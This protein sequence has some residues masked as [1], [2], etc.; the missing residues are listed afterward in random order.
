[1]TAIMQYPFAVG[2]RGTHSVSSNNDGEDLYASWYAIFAGTQPTES[3]S[4]HPSLP[5]SDA[6]ADGEADVDRNQDRSSP[7]P[8]RSPF[9]SGTLQPS[10]ATRGTALSMRESY[11]KFAETPPSGE[12][13]V[14]STQTSAA[15]VP[16]KSITSIA[17]SSAVARQATGCHVLESETKASA[18]SVAVFVRGQQVAVVVRDPG[19]TEAVAMQCAFAAARELTGSNSG[20]RQLTVNGRLLYRQA[21][22]TAS[23]TPASMFSC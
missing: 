22:S 9:A 15:V 2:D 8:L 3:L 10:A 14:A 12:L 13:S 6:R 16:T 7:A 23:S 5:M 11:A 17:E 18:D 20:L 1:M 4:E 19:I 21:A